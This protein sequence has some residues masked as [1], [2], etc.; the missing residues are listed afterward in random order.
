MKKLGLTLTAIL[1]GC[2]SY[3]P[4]N[5]SGGFSHQMISESVYEVQFTGSAFNDLDEI[6]DLAKLRAAEIG[7]DLGF[8][9]VYFG[10]IENQS[11]QN[12]STTY[13]PQ[14]QTVATGRVG[15]D[16][17]VVNETYMMPNTI[18]VNIPK[19]VVRANYFDERPEQRLLSSDLHR[20]ESLIQALATK[21]NVKS[22]LISD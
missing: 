2:A 14:T 1:F 18:A 3:G 20:V 4:M 13:T 6:S 17:F 7:R 11:F 15:N 21:H 9:Y 19:I 5:A 12:K 8:E 16:K 10:S 22:L